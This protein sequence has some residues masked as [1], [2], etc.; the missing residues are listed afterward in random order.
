[1]N[2]QFKDIREITYS[3]EMYAAK[4]R[5]FVAAFIYIV[6]FILLGSLAWAYYS[7]ID[8]IARGNGV[9]RPDENISTIRVEFA[10]NL[11]KI[12]VFEGKVV[13]KGDL[14][15]AIDHKTLTL[16]KDEII[17]Q[18]NEKQQKLTHL[19]AYK[20]NIEN[21]AEPL[22]DDISAQ[23]KNL[24]EEYHAL[25]N[26]RQSIAQ[27]RDLTRDSLYS[28]MFQTYKGNID[29]LASQLQ[30]SKS[31]YERIKL[32]F[33]SGMISRNEYEDAQYD[34]DNKQMAYNNYKVD[35]I[36]KLEERITNTKDSIEQ[37]VSQ[38]IEQAEDEIDN[39]QLELDKVNIKIAETD[40]VAPIDGKVNL[41]KEVS[42]GEYVAFGTELLTIIPETGAGYT[43]DIVLPNKEIAG[44]KLDDRVKFRFTALPFKEYGEFNGNITQISVNTRVDEM[45]NSYYL[46]KA[47]LDER[48]GISYKGEKRSI[49]VGMTCEA[50]II[51]EQKKVLYWLLEKIN[52]ID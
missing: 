30:Y 36:A 48:E 20:S 29:R 44:L 31:N 11:E 35:Y 42:N 18:L 22:A 49:K 9:V 7:E 17:E 32:I 23:L 33:E 6:L 1:M 16:Q 51:K 40:I 15:Y 52:L 47:N 38:E 25:L 10:G 14:L 39:Y 46:A 12:N 2:S 43:V 4:P 28:N 8:I 26:L 3:R 21:S 37:V 24:R 19:T 13:K 45:G 5:P 41:L 50:H 34:L 27:N